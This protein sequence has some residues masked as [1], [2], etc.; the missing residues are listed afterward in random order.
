MDKAL[1]RA[2]KLK[3]IIDKLAVWEAN[4]QKEMDSTDYAANQITSFMNE[5]DY[6]VQID[7][8][9]QID[10]LI[11]SLTSFKINY[12][13]DEWVP[14]D[15]IEQYDYDE[16]ERI[17]LKPQPIPQII[18]VRYLGAR[19]TTRV[20]QSSFCKRQPLSPSP[21]SGR[22][23]ACTYPPQQTWQGMKKDFPSNLCVMTQK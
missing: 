7:L 5:D 14:E 15:D 23:F 9:K 11:Y 3:S 2:R 12:D 6:P 4:K 21:N 17:P 13:E 20:S 22:L 10:E 18:S 19:N 16:T 8:Q 1:N